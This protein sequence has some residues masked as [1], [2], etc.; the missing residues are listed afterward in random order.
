MFISRAWQLATLV[1]ALGLGACATA[2]PSGPSVFATPSQGKSF[3][4]F[5][6]EDASCRQVAE[7]Q[8]GNQQRYDSVYSQC[9]YSL[10]NSVASAQRHYP[11][12][13]P[14]GTYDASGGNGSNWER[15]ARPAWTGPD[16]SDAAP[17][18]QYDFCDDHPC[19]A[20]FTKAEMDE[21][22]EQQRRKQQE[23][24][25][26]AQRQHD[27]EEAAELNRRR[28][29]WSS[30]SGSEQKRQCV[31]QCQP[32]VDSCHS[33]NTDHAWGTMW[34]SGASLGSAVRADMTSTNCSRVY[35]SCMDSCLEGP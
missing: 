23:A 9:M 25:A 8:P 22:E 17:T 12:S 15:F 13:S 31:V 33:H 3:E 24:A 29:A 1:G 35:D 21:Y 32:R 11:T 28:V 26:A 14:A 2:Q 7:A 6:Q 20:P 5:Q 18:K 27:Q 19:H 10:G 30:L 34:S 4:V 16:L